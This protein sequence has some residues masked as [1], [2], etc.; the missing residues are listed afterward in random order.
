MSSWMTHRVTRR[1]VL[2]AIYA[3]VAGS[4][5]LAQ[6][7]IG[8][9]PHKKGPTV[10]LDY[11]QVEL[12]AAYNQADYAPNE[13][14]IA[15]RDASINALVR[16][17]L[18]A[19]QRVAYGP[20]EIE[21]L[22]LYRTKRAMSPV[23]IFFHGGAW[24]GGSAADNSYL[25]E[26]FVNAGAHFAVPDFAAVQDVGGSLMLME[27]QVRRAIAWV[28]KN[29]HTFGGDPDRVYVSA[30]SSGAHLAGAALLT[31][32]RK[33]FGFPGNMIRGALLVSG[34][35]DLKGPR[36]S[37]RSSHVKFD[38]A[39]E[40]ALSTQR[41]IDKIH[42]PLTVAY[43]SLDTPEFQRQSREFAAALKAAGKPVELIRG[44]GHNHF[45]FIETLGNPYGLLGST[46]LGQ[47]GLAK[48]SPHTP[49]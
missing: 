10:F 14:Q 2:G 11:D 4:P 5:L 42:T 47:M 12:D 48:A 17:R 16:T 29:A 39:T 46:A 24:R 27:G 43:A 15:E 35:Y 32:W 25:A 23:L 44:A 45:E 21:R 37:S 7:Q 6:R 8:P 41:H 3:T 33:D 36:L 30:H 9:P 18:G 40:D 1:A 20:S 22:D 13:E 38:D 28:Y 34:I 26:N 19:P 49:A 31:D